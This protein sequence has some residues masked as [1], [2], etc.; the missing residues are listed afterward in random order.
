MHMDITLTSTKILLKN[1][2]QNLPLTLTS[3]FS[4][5]KITWQYC[6]ALEL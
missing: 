4:S 2:S 1:I 6:I 3:Y 5:I